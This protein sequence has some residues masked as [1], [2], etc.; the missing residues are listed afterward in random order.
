MTEPQAPQDSRIAIVYDGE[1]YSFDPEDL[2]LEEGHEIETILGV[3]VTEAKGFGLAMVA[4]YI[5][6]RHE[7]PKRSPEQVAA[8]VKAMKLLKVEFVAD[9][10]EPEEEAEGLPTVGV[11]GEHRP[12]APSGSVTTRGEP[13]SRGMA[14]SSA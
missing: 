13:G 9:E 11:I 1:R 6:K 10:P 5:G 7:D 8:E 3:D 4:Y 12:V 14:R 2:T